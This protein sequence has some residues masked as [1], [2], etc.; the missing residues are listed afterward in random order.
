MGGTTHP[1]NCFHHWPACIQG[2]KHRCSCPE[3]YSR[4]QAHRF[5]CGLCIHQC[6]HVKIKWQLSRGIVI[7]QL[8]FVNSSHSALIFFSPYL[9]RCESPHWDSNLL[10]IHTGNCQRCSHSF[11]PGR[12]LAAPDTR[13]YLKKQIVRSI[14]L[15]SHF[16]LDNIFL[17]DK[18]WVL[19]QQN[20]IAPAI[21]NSIKQ[22]S[23]WFTFQD[24]SDRVGSESLSS[25]TESLIFR[26]RQ[27]KDKT[28]TWLWNN[29]Q[30]AII[31]AKT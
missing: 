9:H 24:D 12:D 3:C 22:K 8:E 11:H 28:V 25:W 2:D 17:N 14:S 15:C 29:Q 6:L 13:R 31:I 27:D 26:Y 5:Q 20:P 10:D 19:M 16:I 18:I 21:V 23:G 7:I 30:S 4:Y 1:C